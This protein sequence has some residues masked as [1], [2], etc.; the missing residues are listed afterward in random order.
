M[1]KNKSASSDLGNEG[2]ETYTRTDISTNIIMLSWIEMKKLYISQV[3]NF[4]EQEVYANFM[5]DN[6]VFSSKGTITE[7]K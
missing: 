4:N 5:S 2:T 6:S 7:L 1:E 3:I